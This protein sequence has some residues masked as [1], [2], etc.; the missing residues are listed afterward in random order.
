LLHHSLR[1]FRVSRDK[2]AL[3]HL[4]FADDLVIFT[5]ATSSKASIVKTCLNKYSIWLGQSVNISKSNI[6][7]SKN[8]TASTISDFRVFF[9]LLTL[10]YQQSIWVFLC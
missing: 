5:S 7:F 4:V 3:N 6:L 9:H 8:T 1:G 10:Q 2:M